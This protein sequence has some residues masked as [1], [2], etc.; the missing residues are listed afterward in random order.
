V[1]ANGVY[2]F[3]RESGASVS[4]TLPVGIMP[5]A[6]E[7]DDAADT[8]DFTLIRLMINL[9]LVMADNPSQPAPTNTSF[10]LKAKL[11]ESDAGFAEGRDRLKFAYYQNGWQEIYETSPKA[12]GE[13]VFNLTSWPADPMVGV[14]RR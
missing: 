2:T 14:G 7:L 11:F 8:A 9:G 5:V 6:K 12:A 10:T 3:S 13:A 1:Y 4:L